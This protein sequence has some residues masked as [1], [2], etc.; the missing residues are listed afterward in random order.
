M[1]IQ[2]VNASVGKQAHKMNLFVF[3]TGIGERIGENLILFNI[4]C[5]ALLIYLYK[6]LVNHSSGSDIK[7]ANFRI[8]HLTIRQSDILPGCMKPGIWI[9]V[10]IICKVWCRYLASVSYT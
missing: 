2:G 10:F 7:M 1:F 6:I 8:S 3:V 4:S 5:L 9:I